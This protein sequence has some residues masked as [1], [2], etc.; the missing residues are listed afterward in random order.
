MGSLC[1]IQSADTQKGLEASP[2]VF[3]TLRA[4]FDW[5]GLQTMITQPSKPVPPIGEYHFAMLEPDARHEES[6]PPR[7][8]AKEFADNLIL[9]GL[10]GPRTARTYIVRRTAPRSI[11]QVHCRP[12]HRLRCSVVPTFAYWWLNP[13][14]LIEIH[15][16]EHGSPS[17]GPS[18]AAAQR[19]VLTD[20]FNR[21]PENAQRIAPRSPRV[22]ANQASRPLHPTLALRHCGSGSSHYPAWPGRSIQLP[23]SRHKSIR[24][25]RSGCA[26]R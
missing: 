12:N 2:I 9:S 18:S 26:P 3:F 22:A 13:Y 1:P 15:K 21:S 25:R 16:D 24:K 23:S 17:P 19:T 7:V 14:K 6:K 11:E 10:I 4:H 20:V 5:Q 8:L